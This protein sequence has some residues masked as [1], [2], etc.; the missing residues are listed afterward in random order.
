MVVVLEVRIFHDEAAVP[1]H[2]HAIAG[3]ARR[4]DAVK[5]VDAARDTLDE[6]VGRAD[7][8]EIARLVFRQERRRVFEHFI[9]EFGRLADGQ[10]ADCIARQ[11]HV[12]ELCRVPF[13][14]ILVH[15]ALHDAKQALIRGR[16]DCLAPLGPA[17]RALRRGFGIVV[18]GRI[19]HALVKCHDDVGAKAHLRLHRDFGRQELFRT[20]DMR[21]ERHAFLGDFAQVA[22]AED[23]ESAAVRQD[24]A[25]PMHELVQAAGLLDEVHARPQE[26]MVR[27]GKNDA[28]AKALQ[29]VRRNALDRRLRADR[30]ENRCRETPVRRVQNARARARS[31]IL[32]YEFVCDCW[33]QKVT[34]PV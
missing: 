10:A 9:H 11:V 17:L 21:A 26:K 24:C 27:I 32:L 34:S 20:V 1:G 13:A 7:A 8:H 2:R 6:V 16:H 22:K 5:H 25:I 33:S 15:A 23:L 19:R 31:F 14:Q 12:H 28:G 29:F 4:I 30:H 3:D 18:I